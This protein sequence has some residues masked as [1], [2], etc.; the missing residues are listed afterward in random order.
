MQQTA[1]DPLQYNALV[2][3]ERVHRSLYTDPH[4]FT[5]EL[6]K[7]FYRG[8]VFIA[9]ESENPSAGRLYDAPSW[10]PVGHL[11]A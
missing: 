10:Q 6:E 4:I 8:W 5:D 2:Q 11:G 1:L 7:I 9:H 3:N